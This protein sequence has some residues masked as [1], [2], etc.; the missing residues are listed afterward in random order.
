M[1]TP[2]NNNAANR[3]FFFNIGEIAAKKVAAKRQRKNL[4]E[5]KPRERSYYQTLFVNQLSGMAALALVAPLERLRIL[6]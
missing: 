1:A 5:L 4:P 6:R 3:N 2:S